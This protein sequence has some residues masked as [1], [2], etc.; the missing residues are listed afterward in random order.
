M[1]Q[2]LCFA[3]KVSILVFWVGYPRPGTD[4]PDLPLLALW[5]LGRKGKQGIHHYYSI[6]LK[7]VSSRMIPILEN[8]Q[9]LAKGRDPTDPIVSLCDRSV[10]I[11]IRF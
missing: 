5:P 2:V 11:C 7:V 9:M 3:L 4:E 1:I 8:F 6:Y 10:H